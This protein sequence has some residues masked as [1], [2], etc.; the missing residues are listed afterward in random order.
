MKPM[1]IFFLLTTLVIASASKA[2]N[3]EDHSAPTPVSSNV[4][5]TSDRPQRLPDG[6]VFI[7]K[8]SQYT[9]GLRTLMAVSAS[10]AKT[11][12]LNG[13]V[14]AD[15]SAYGVV[16]AT[17][18][19][20]LSAP[21]KGFPALGSSVKKGQLLGWIEPVFDPIEHG[22]Q[23][24]QIADL[25][26]RIAV[27]QDRTNR[28]KGLEDYVPKNEREQVA[29]ELAAA[30]QS[31][32][33]LMGSLNKR[34]ELRAPISGQLAQIHAPMGS[35]LTAG[36]LIFTLIDTSRLQI[37]A[38][39]FDLQL[40]RDIHAASARTARGDILALTPLGAGVQLKEQA[41][42]ILFRVD[43]GAKALAVGEPLEVNVQV[44]G[45]IQ[46]FALP[47][48][49]LVNHPQGGSG[50]WLMMG[51]EFFQLHRVVTQPLDASHV[52]ITQGVQAG[53]RVVVERAAL[54]SQIR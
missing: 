11:L 23:T 29:A 44:G 34:Q 41:L 26:G 8:T 4:T 43:S 9:L 39:G 19:G 1:A 7:P 40:V 32:Q 42:P 25:N 10:H 35:V 53:D 13:H 20:R 52:V 14:Q 30:R 50:V 15:P 28:F 18:N 22:R 37:E 16:A 24:Q 48:T 49:A 17:G 2:H 46:G 47:L 45:K 3:G 27:L 21:D 54:I 31:R 33:E 6:R 5:V 12:V 36:Q 51:P 38:L